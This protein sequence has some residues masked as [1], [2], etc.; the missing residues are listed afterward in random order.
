MELL[1]I[2]QLASDAQ[3]PGCSDAL[4]SLRLPRPT[5]REEDRFK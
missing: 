5:G 4:R 3:V 2:E 1:G